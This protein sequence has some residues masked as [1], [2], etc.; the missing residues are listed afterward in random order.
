MLISQYHSMKKCCVITLFLYL[1]LIR[2]ACGQDVARL[3]YR[4]DTTRSDTSK[5]LVLY[6]ISRYYWERNADSVLL[7]GQKAKELASRVHFER[8]L[9]LAWLSMG[10]AW[11]A[12]EEYAEAINCY[13]QS[14]HFSEEL[15]DEGLSCSIYGNMGAIYSQR[16]LNGK[17][18][19]YYAASFR[20]AEKN[21]DR[22]QMAILYINIGEACK[23]MG[24]Y[25]SSIYYNH[26]ALPILQE[27]KD[28]I[29]VAVVF[30]N[31]GEGYLR[32]KKAA[33]ALL[34]FNRCLSLAR[35]LRDE[36]DIEWS[37]VDMAQVYALEKKYHASIHYAEMAL[38]K[39]KRTSFS[40][41]VQAAYP[42]LYTDYRTLHAF[43]KALDYRNQEIAFKDSLYTL[44]KE[45]KIKSLES[46]YEIEKQQHQIDL[47]NE[48]KLLQAQVIRGEHQRHIM[49]AAA[50]LFFAMWAFFLFKSNQEKERLNRQLKAQNR[51]IQREQEDE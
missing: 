8:G 40:E 51:V 16:G 13:L 46:S 23:R 2:Q 47:L 29:N 12:K 6:S 25:D 41:V 30:L 45:K 31:V 7:M 10:I 38:E 36:E 3:F 43:G 1:L 32:E 26:A 39:S 22:H 48:N 28:S 42:V 11:G 15:K 33:E 21:N 34:Y 44:A 9:G 35:T 27:Q 5:V 17:A 50:T 20:M 19:E 49:L 4:L 24:D 18:R 14:L 37:F